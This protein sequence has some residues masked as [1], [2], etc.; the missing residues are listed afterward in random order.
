VTFPSRY[1]SLDLWRGVACLAVIICH[2][3]S[4]STGWAEP[5]TGVGHHGVTIFFVISGYCIAAAA[6]HAMRT[7]L[8]LRLYFWRR[9][10]R[11]FPPFWALLAFAAFLMFGLAAIGRS[12]LLTEPLNDV[13]LSVINDPRSLNAWQFVG[14]LTLTEIWRVRVSGAPSF[15]L[16]LGHTWTLCYEE[17]F[18]AVTGLLLLLTRHRFGWGVV[19]VSLGVFVCAQL[20]HQSARLGFFFDGLW[21]LFA[22]GTAVFHWRNSQPRRVMIALLAMSVLCIWRIPLFL[23][24]FA[25]GGAFASTLIALRPY[26]RVLMSHRAALPFHA[27]GVRCYSIYLVHWPITKLLSHLIA[28]Q[29]WTGS[30]LTVLVT[31]PLCIAASLALA[32]PFHAYIERRF[33]NASTRVAPTLRDRPDRIFEGAVQTFTP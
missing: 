22:G 15:R 4:Y 30:W 3:G 8:P 33:L 13:T 17:Q 29:G 24:S 31:V 14:N 11:I 26:D 18:Y 27:C 10:R 5:L 9:F 12:A 32:W 23:S 28:N 6:A 2:A 7:A 21:L 20:P 19:V 16:L 1:E 25:V